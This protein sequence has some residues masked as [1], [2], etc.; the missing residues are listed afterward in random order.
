MQGVCLNETWELTD[1]GEIHHNNRKP[2]QVIKSLRTK[3]VLAGLPDIK[4]EQKHAP[5]EG[6]MLI[7]SIELN[8][9]MSS[10]ESVG[11]IDGSVL[12]NKNVTSLKS[13]GIKD[14]YAENA[15]SKEIEEFSISTQEA[16]LTFACNWNESLNS[17]D[18]VR[19]EGKYISVTI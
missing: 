7:E 18:R 2:T 14:L 16:P 19:F 6:D 15:I 17:I 12:C 8:N 9:T 4:F 3:S 10:C 11:E 13:K 1:E 5:K